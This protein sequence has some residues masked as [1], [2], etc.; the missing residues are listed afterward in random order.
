MSGG[1]Q[2]RVAVARALVTNPDLILCD[3]PTGALDTVSAAEVLSLLEELQQRDAVWSS[4]P[5]RPTSPPAPGT[6]S[7][8]ATG[9]SSMT[10]GAKR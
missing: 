7:V 9:C 3:E 2:Q 10:V 1:Q 4:S 8:S 6:S 5:T